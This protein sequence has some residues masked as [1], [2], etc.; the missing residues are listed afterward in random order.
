MFIRS[1]AWGPHR[2]VL[3]FTDT[4]PDWSF[5]IECGEEVI[6]RNGCRQSAF[7]FFSGC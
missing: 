4:N 6:I 3:F 1:D 2:G 5:V 7:E